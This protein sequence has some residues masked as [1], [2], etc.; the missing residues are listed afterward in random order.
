MKNY[1]LSPGCCSRTGETVYLK[2]SCQSLRIFPPPPG[3]WEQEV[4]IPIRD[5]DPDADK[6]RANIA[7]GMMFTSENFIPC[8]HPDC[9]ICCGQ[10]KYPTEEQVAAFEARPKVENM[11][12]ILPGEE[13]LFAEDDLKQRERVSESMRKLRRPSLRRRIFNAV[14]RLFRGS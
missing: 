5:S 9:W 6:K 7:R 1:G 8:Q 4:C 12:G 2:L 10:A 11:F 13:R 14:M 3:Y